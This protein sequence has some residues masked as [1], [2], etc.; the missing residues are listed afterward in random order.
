MNHEIQGDHFGDQ[1]RIRLE[2]MT[3]QFYLP[4][5]NNGSENELYNAN[6]NDPISLDL[7]KT[8]KNYYSF[9]L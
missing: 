1:D 4:I 8:P 2:G 7:C 3:A 5:L 6:A 9:F